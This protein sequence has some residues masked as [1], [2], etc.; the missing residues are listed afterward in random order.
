[1]DIIEE[2]AKEFYYDIQFYYSGFC[3]L[4]KK[5]RIKYKNERSRDILNTGNNIQESKLLNFSYLKLSNLIN[6][7]QLLLKITIY[8]SRSNN[9]CYNRENENESCCVSLFSSDVIAWIELICVLIL[10]SCCVE[11]LYYYRE[12]E[13]KIL[14]SFENWEQTCL[15]LII[16][17]IR[18]SKFNW[19]L[20]VYSNI[21]DYVYWYFSS[22]KYIIFK[23]NV[24]LTHWSSILRLSHSQNLLH[25]RDLTKIFLHLYHRNPRKWEIWKKSTLKLSKIMR[26]P[27]KWKGKKK[28]KIKK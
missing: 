24:S 6:L 17:A 25:S 26:F 10:T 11:A 27:L 8:I 19:N 20:Y 3:S 18:A 28:H 16:K 4:K 9:E 7:F 21:N 23:M 13:E 14:I 12:R 22:Q 1:L 2:I 5:G 15:K